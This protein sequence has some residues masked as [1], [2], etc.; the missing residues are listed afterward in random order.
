MDSSFSV[1]S[2]EKIFG[3]LIVPASSHTRHLRDHPHI[4]TR[5]AAR[6]KAAARLVSRPPRLVRTHLCTC[7]RASRSFTPSSPFS[8]TDD[9]ETIVSRAG[10][11]SSPTPP[12]RARIS[13]RERPRVRGKPLSDW[14]VPEKSSRRSHDRHT[15]VRNHN[16]LAKACPEAGSPSGLRTRTTRAR[17]PSATRRPPRVRRPLPA[18]NETW[19]IRP[20][21]ARDTRLIRRGDRR[22]APLRAFPARLDPPHYSRKMPRTAN[23]PLLF[24]TSRAASRPRRTSR[25]PSPS[26]RLGHRPSATSE[27]AAELYISSTA[28]RARRAREAASTRPPRRDPAGKSTERA[29]FQL[30]VL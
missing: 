10:A 8:E 14:R 29:Q 30:R 6:P 15:L 2:S 16:A 20:V 22:D 18:R 13:S 17:A 25:P 4:S 24:S 21:F 9:I 27:S 23:E 28:T 26:P 12:P 5:R 7:R 11:L 3:G 1:S 19:S